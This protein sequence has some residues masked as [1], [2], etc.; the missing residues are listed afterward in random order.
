MKAIL[1]A[2][3]LLAVLVPVASAQVVPTPRAGH[4]L[5]VILEDGAPFST[6]TTFSILDTIKLGKVGFQLRAGCSPPECTIPQMPSCAQACEDHCSYFS[7]C[8]CSGDY[9]GTRNVNGICNIFECS[10][11][12]WAFC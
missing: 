12:W 11:P 6:L 3:L 7:V 2:T 5:R 10:G 1:I 9:D 8:S 4:E